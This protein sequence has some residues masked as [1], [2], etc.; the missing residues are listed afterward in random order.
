MNKT[1]GIVGAVVVVAGVAWYVLSRPPTTIVTPPSSSMEA[2]VAPEQ[3]QSATGGASMGSPQAGVDVS[4]NA[5]AA[6]TQDIVI[7]GRKFSFTPSTIT[8][9]KGTVVRINFKN[10]DGFHD[11]VIDEF[12]VATP[13]INGGEAATVT[14]TADKV[15]SFEYYCSVGNHRA[16]GMVGTLT[17]TE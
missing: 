7:E 5:G 6:L 12:S 4:V 8:V 16:M 15:G 10:I 3:P 13:Q 17:V 9:K 2:S 11:L 1:I 14:F